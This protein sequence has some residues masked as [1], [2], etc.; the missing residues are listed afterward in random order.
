MDSEKKIIE[1]LRELSGQEEIKSSDNLQDDVSLD[2]LGMVTLLLEVEDAF[3]ITLD[4]SD[5][6]PLDL[7]T[8]NDVINLVRKYRGA[9]NEKNC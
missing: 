6:N 8:V 3:N 5:M 2:S 4:E 1:L 9:R 7:E